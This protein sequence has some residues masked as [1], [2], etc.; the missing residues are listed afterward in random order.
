MSGG[1]QLDVPGEGPCSSEAVRWETQADSKTG[2]WRTDSRG[3]RCTLAQLAGFPG[4]SAAMRSSSLLRVTPV[5]GPLGGV[6]HSSCDFG[7][8]SAVEFGYP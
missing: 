8:G 2:G 4:D 5:W 6:R 1:S 3:H 7:S